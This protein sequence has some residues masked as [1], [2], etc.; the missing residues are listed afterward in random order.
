MSPAD[1]LRGI[2]GASPWEMLGAATGFVSV[3]LMARQ[4]VWG[5]PVG[6]VCVS[7]YAWVFGQSRLYANMALQFVFLALQVYGWVHWWKGTG[8]RHEA[9]PVTRLTLW[10]ATLWTVAGAAAS[11][12]LG[13]FM[14]SRTDAA[15]PWPD[16]TLTA[17]SLVAQWLQAR[18][19][20]ECWIVWILVDVGYIGL[21]LVQRLH[22]TAVLYAL[23]LVLCVYALK[24]W[25][26][27]IAPAAA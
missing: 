25:R 20:F 23:F 14:A 8:N 7:A 2:L 26:C 4:S 18:K 10:A 24:E 22:L 12:A 1:L 19:V 6:I 15:N 17:F 11:V 21:F 9:L 13:A 27:S 3:W 16:A 5:W